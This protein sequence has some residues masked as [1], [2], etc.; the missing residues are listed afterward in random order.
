M[1]DRHFYN[2]F[3]SVLERIYGTFNKQRKKFEK[4]SNSKIA[5]EL[6]YSDSQFS[7]LV[8]NSAT[9]GEYERAIRNANRYLNELRLSAQSEQKK[10]NGD[11][12]SLFGKSF[13][14]PTL[15]ASVPLAFLLILFF[16]GYWSFNITEAAAEVERD[17]MLKWI[18]ENSSV[19]PYM[20]LDELPSDCSYPCYKYQGQWR[21][22]ETYKIPV[23]R[24]RNGFHYLAKSVNLYT[25]CNKEN[26]DE[27]T[28]MEG[29]EYQEHE[30][31]YDKRE[32]QID[33]FL[34]DE[35]RTLV[36][37]E[38]RNMVFEEEQNFVKVAK[39]HTFFRN[40]FEIDST[41]IAREGMVIGRDVEVI[42]DEILLENLGTS[43]MV[44]DI[45]REINSI[46]INRVE[47]FSRPVSCSN[48]PLPDQNIHNIAELDT[49]SFNCQLTTANAPIQYTKTYVLNDQY[50]ETS[51]RPNP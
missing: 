11:G 6:C 10:H 2:E 9:E 30:I 37:D 29:Y 23:F 38:Y 42:D 14:S 41:S 49:M 22:K 1:D 21:L 34:V 27:G 28:Q 31:W 50:I 7:R 8:N 15:F 35:D 18:F 24:E 16:Y 5:R 25:R 36:T 13:K 45:K 32:L 44:E 20:N 17:S 48:S 12:F 4:A 19:S 43:D 51:C 46:V 39:V 3:I 26:S 33:S 47:D 40:E